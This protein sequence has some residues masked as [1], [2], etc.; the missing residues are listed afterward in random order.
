[1]STSLPRYDVIEKSVGETPL[2]ALE[3]YRSSAGISSEVPLAYAGRLDPM[4]SGTLLILIGDECK[5]QSEYHG[6]DKAYSF[7][8]LFG[9]GSDTYD[10][11]GRLTAAVPRHITAA[12]LT[13]TLTQFRGAISLPYPPFS[14]KTVQGKPLHT[15][16]LEKRLQEIEVPE[17]HST[18]YRLTLK[19]VYMRTGAELAT[20][21]AHKIQTVTPVTDSRK[22]LGA[23]FRRADVLKDWQELSERYSDTKFALADLYCVASSGTYM[24]SLSHHI[25]ATLDIP[26]LAWSIHRETIGCY[27]PILRQWGF[28]SQR[29]R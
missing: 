13:T 2:Q 3:R 6:L 23:D 29:F 22:A 15:W 25:G 5:R 1:M 10:P 14:A 17:R 9:V 18:V 12:E 24:R 20:S 8:I 7:T 21:A 11:L 26:A 19:K 4:A 16:T 27:R 28:F